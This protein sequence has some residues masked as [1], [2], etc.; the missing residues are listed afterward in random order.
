MSKRVSMVNNIKVTNVSS[1]SVFQVGDS[2]KVSPRS[3][4]LAVQRQV[5]LFFSDEGNFEMF[6]LFT[7]P[8]PKMSF[9]EPISINR[10]ND[11]RFINVK[12]I[13]IISAASSGVLHIG[14]TNDIHAEARIK[15]IRQLQST[16]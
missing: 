12:N 5:E 10:Y 9:F 16:E 4:A 3:R 15:H 7:R 6:P 1:S 8:I 14:S 13:N 2:N 11:S